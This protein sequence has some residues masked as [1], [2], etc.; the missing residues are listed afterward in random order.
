M[1][2]PQRNFTP[3]SLGKKSK[4][5]NKSFLRFLFSFIAVVACALFII[6]SLGVSGN[7]Q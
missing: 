4:L 1:V 2:L 6:L 7:V 3:S 5:I